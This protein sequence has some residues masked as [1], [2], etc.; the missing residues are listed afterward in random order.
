MESVGCLVWLIMQT[1]LA[2]N[3]EKVNSGSCTY[4]VATPHLLQEEVEAR[5]KLSKS[6]P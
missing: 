2:V 1:A 6:D 3:R 5:F 4:I